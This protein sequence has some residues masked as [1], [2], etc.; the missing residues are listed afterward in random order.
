MAQRPTNNKQGTV[1]NLSD[2]LAGLAVGDYGVSASTS[3]MLNRQHSAIGGIVQNKHNSQGNLSVLNQS[4]DL[5]WTPGGN[6]P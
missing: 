4:L 1:G 3:N 5:G 2:S 6:V